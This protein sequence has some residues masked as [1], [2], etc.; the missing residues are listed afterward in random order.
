ML[1]ELLCGAA[2]RARRC[3]A[4]GKPTAFARTSRLTPAP[5]LMQIMKN[6]FGKRFR[7]TI[8]V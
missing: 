8:A 5:P 7:K 6:D 4:A 3:D 1:I 2:T